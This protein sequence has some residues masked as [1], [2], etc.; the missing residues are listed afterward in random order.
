MRPLSGKK[1]L[2]WLTIFILL[3]TFVVGTILSYELQKSTHN[4]ITRLEAQ[5]LGK[6]AFE[7]LHYEMIRQKELHS[8]GSKNRNEIHEKHFLS[9][10]KIIK[11][12]VDDRIKKSLSRTISDEKILKKLSNDETVVLDEG[13]HIVLFYPIR[14]QKSCHQCHK[15]YSQDKVVAALQLTVPS[16]IMNRSAADIAVAFRSYFFIFIVIVIVVYFLSINRL[17]ITP[18]VNLSERIKQATK[19]N[20]TDFKLPTSSHLAEI[21][22]LAESFNT[23]LKRISFYYDKM[24]ES[25]YLDSDT[26]LPNFSALKQDLSKDPKR[27]YCIVI[28]NINRFREINRFYGFNLG[29][30]ILKTLAKSIVDKLGDKENH[31]YHLGGDKFAWLTPTYIDYIELIELLEQLHSKPFVYQG[32]EIYIT[33]ACGIA[34]GHERLIEHAEIALQRAKE[35]G[36]PFE[37]FEDIFISEEKTHD[38]IIWTQRLVKAVQENRIVIHYQPIFNIEKAKAEKFE[39]LIRMLDQDGKTIYSPAK[40]MDIAKIS[41]LYLRLTRIVVDQAFTYFADRPYQFSINLAMKDIAD[42]PT[43]HYILNKLAEFP[44]ATRVTF[45]ILESEAINDFEMLHEFSDAVRQKGAKIAIDDFG[46]GYS[47]YEYIVKL[48]PD[49]IKIDGSL[50]RSIDQDEKIEA[51]V[52]SIVQVAHDLKIKSVAEFVH[53]KTVFQKIESLGI[54]FVQGYFINA[55]VADPDIYLNSIEPK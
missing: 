41:G 27:N 20:K 30:Y 35:S 54:D 39:C 51:V 3:A 14:T 36:R 9:N 1:F 40:F 15:A 11:F 37:T 22:D 10:L 55:P 18:L 49:Y 17:L 38:N 8:H 42:A 26:K 33:L 47:N 19:E 7:T 29:D 28:F 44:D 2:V 50:I 16:D 6:T 5:K 46:S 13:E 24:I 48:S 25:L 32:S 21:K 23:L 12:D 43:R 4:I 31:I 52:R 53:S 45:E 34:H